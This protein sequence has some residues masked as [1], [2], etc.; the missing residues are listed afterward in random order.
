MKILK[1]ILVAVNFFAANVIYSQDTPAFIRDSLDIYV[2]RSL[3]IWKV[4]GVAVAVVKDGKVIWMKGY[5]TREL[6]KNEPVDENT[7]FMIGSNTKQFTGMSLALL[8]SDEKCSLNDKVKKWMPEFT[9]KD[10]W[11]AN[12]LTLTD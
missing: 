9:M 2:N 4:P 12:E 11:V 10:A 5:G 8:E 7:L 6:N 1:T 3:E